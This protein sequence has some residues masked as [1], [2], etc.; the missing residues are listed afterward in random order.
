GKLN[1]NTRFSE[2]FGLVAILGGNIRNNTYRRFI[3]TTEGGLNATD[4]FNLSN[5]VSPAV[6]D[7][8]TDFKRVSS[9]FASTS[10][11]YKNM[12][13]VDLT[14]RIDWSS[15]LPQENRMFDYPS[16]S[17]SFVFTELENFR[18]NNIL[19]FGKIRAGWAAVGN[20]TDPYQYYE[21]YDMNPSL[22]G[23]AS[24]SNKSL[25]PNPDLLA[26]ET[27]QW[28]VGTDLRFFKNRVRLDF[29]YYH[30]R[31]F[32]QILELPISASTG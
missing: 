21:S 2:N 3:G 29:T 27:S 14:Y 5:S 23:N 16:I 18:G 11:D 32:N 9:V 1:Y 28:E 17:G 19:T 8:Y 30:S 4:F 10:W 13:Y 7:Q 6:T 22:G 12:L 25:L 24:I 15:A 26:E 20:D 31:S